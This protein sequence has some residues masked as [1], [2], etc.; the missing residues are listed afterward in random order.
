MDSSLRKKKKFEYSNL[1]FRKLK[2][3]QTLNVQYIICTRRRILREVTM[4]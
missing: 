4:I 1:S 3:N 2:F